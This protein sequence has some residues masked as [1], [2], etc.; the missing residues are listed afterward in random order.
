MVFALG[1]AHEKCG[2][3]L[4]KFLIFVAIYASLVIVISVTL[5]IYY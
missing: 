2:H 3:S 5:K 1:I 4:K